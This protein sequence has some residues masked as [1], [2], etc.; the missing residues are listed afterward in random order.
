MQ[1]TLQMVVGGALLGLAACSNADAPAQPA[2]AASQAQALIAPEPGAQPG[3]YQTREV[4]LRLLGTQG[5]GAT[6]SATL[7]DTAT[8]YTQT[9]R[10]GETIGRNLK[11]SAVRADAVELSAP[12][13]AAQRIPAGGELRLR[14]VEHEFDRAAVEQG[15]HQWVVRAPVMARLFARYG[16]GAMAAPVEYAGLPAVRL[17]AVQPGSALSR[18]G[19]AGGDLIFEYNGQPATAATPAA[20]AADATQGR[21][22]VLTVKM[23][24]GGS[25]WERAYVVQ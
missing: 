4:T 12:G 15:D 22:Q 16:V 17:A 8:F 24:R 11:V 10:V 7:T 2:T 5:E 6:A 1:K 20:L 23:G 14:L 19:F 18:L 9:Y 21:S 25:L 13:A 3:E